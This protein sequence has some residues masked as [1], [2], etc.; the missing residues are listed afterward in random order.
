MSKLRLLVID[1]HDGVQN[2]IEVVLGRILPKYD[3]EPIIT[4]TRLD[5]LVSKERAL[6]WYDENK[7]LLEDNDLFIVGD[8]IPMGRPLMEVRLDKPTIYYITNRF[9]YENEGI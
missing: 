8:T 9:D 2:E 1:C 5:Y 4:Q 3:L 6:S 7:Q